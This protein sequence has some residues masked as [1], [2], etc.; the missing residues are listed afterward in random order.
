MKLTKAQRSVLVFLASDSAGREVTRRALRCQRRTLKPLVEGGL[1]HEGQNG[2]DS[3]YYYS[4]TNAGRK[5][6]EAQP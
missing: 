5:A 2:F 1:V 6:L 4:L 3:P